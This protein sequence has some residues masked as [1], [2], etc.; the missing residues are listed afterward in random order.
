VT[1]W[2]PVE[3]FETERAATPLEL[4]VDEPSVVLPSRNFTVP[5]GVPDDAVTVALKVT[6]WL[7]I[8]GFGDEVSEVDVGIRLLTVWVSAEE[9]LWA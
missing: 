6:V 3:R 8:E 5:V 1:E 2:E 7:R 9:V 4:S